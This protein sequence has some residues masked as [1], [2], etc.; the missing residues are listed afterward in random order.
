MSAIQH[1]IDALMAQAGRVTGV[2]RYFMRHGDRRPWF[3]RAR[4]VAA[5]AL[6]DQLELSYPRIGRELHRH[7]ASVISLIRHHREDDE[8]RAMLDAL[9]KNT[10]LSAGQLNSVETSP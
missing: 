6:R 7:H 1:E 5:I 4:A 3:M 2:P 8:V 10:P 9:W